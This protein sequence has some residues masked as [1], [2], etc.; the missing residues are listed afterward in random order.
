MAPAGHSQSR[1]RWPKAAAAAAKREAYNRALLSDWLAAATPAAVTFSLP[2]AALLRAPALVAALSPPPQALDGLLLGGDAAASV[3]AR[4]I[5]L[6][7]AYGVTYD[8]G[9]GAAAAALLEP[10]VH[11]GA[12]SQHIAR[13]DEL[14]ASAAIVILRAMHAGTPLKP[15]LHSVHAYACEDAAPRHTLSDAERT[16]L[17]HRRQVAET[18]R[19][20]QQLAGRSAASAPAAR[21][22]EGIGR[23]PE[24]DPLASQ[25]PRGKGGEE[26]VRGGAGSAAAAVRAVKAPRAAAKVNWLTALGSSVKRQQGKR[27][28]GAGRDAASLPQGVVASQASGKLTFPVMFKFNE[29]WRLRGCRHAVGVQAA[30]GLCCLGTHAACEGANGAC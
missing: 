25:A 20:E 11:T 23:G 27:Q 9:S 13:H 16:V 28:M 24:P 15:A 6:L 2:E 5:G 18:Q 30:T 10:A 22:F 14:D 21:S 8:I 7:D 26:V 17:L 4:L 19:R 12:T 29:V 1:L 3:A